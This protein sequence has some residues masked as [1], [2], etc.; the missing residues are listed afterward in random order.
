MEAASRVCKAGR[1]QGQGAESEENGQCVPWLKVAPIRTRSM[2]A[3]A[4]FRAATLSDANVISEVYLASRKRFLPYAPLA[5]TDE[6]VR[7]WIAN[8]LIPHSD[9]SVALVNGEI[10]G[11]MAVSQN[12]VANW[13]N[14]LYIL[15]RAVGQ[16]IGTR[17]I[18]QAKTKSGSPIRL[19]TF[20]A[21][22]GARRFYERHGFKAIAFGDG[23]GNEEK[24]PDVLYEW[25]VFEKIFSNAA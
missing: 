13:I 12:D 6:Q 18:E 21:N 4:V 14:Q 24:C 20:K 19:Y 7:A 23:S 8:Q 16:G 10:V 11:M 22:E 2:E 17:F 5:H 25:S 9:V 1:V 3:A 15:P